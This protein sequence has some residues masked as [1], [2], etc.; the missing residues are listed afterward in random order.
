[1]VDSD[2]VEIL[3]VFKTILVNALDGTS[4]H[5]IYE[6]LPIPIGS[7]KLHPVLK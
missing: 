2:T 5:F 4:Y 3:I 6:K 7:N 1:M